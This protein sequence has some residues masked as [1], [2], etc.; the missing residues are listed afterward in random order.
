MLQCNVQACLTSGHFS[1]E[2]ATR[3]PIGHLTETSLLTY[4]VKSGRANRLC[5][6]C[7]YDLFVVATRFAIAEELH[8]FDFDGLG[9][10]LG[11]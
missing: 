10:V 7:S 8:V 11:V 2:M 3:W 9:V 1:L 4:S 5:V 6:E